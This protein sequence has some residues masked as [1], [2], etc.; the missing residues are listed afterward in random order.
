MI[1]NSSQGVHYIR[2]ILYSPPIGVKTGKW[3]VLMI[4]IDVQRAP[5]VLAIWKGS[6][7]RSGLRIMTIS[8][9]LSLP[10]AMK[11]LNQASRLFDHWDLIAWSFCRE[12]FLINCKSYER[13]ASFHRTLLKSEP[14]VSDD[15]SLMQLT[16][17][18]QL[19]LN[20][21]MFHA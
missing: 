5:T 15:P 4:C 11:T 21:T 9:S 17:Q 16:G 13:V 10:L 1:A 3:Q 18:S 12:H 19:S 2:P 6:W 7:S 20:L 14:N 8:L